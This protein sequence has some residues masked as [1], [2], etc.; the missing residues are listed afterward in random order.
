MANR[1]LSRMLGL[2]PAAPL[3]EGLVNRVLSCSVLAT[4]AVSM[5]IRQG[6]RELLLGGS[7]PFTAAV[8]KF[9][10]QYNM[11][12]V[13][14]SEPFF[15]FIL[16]NLALNWIG[17]VTGLDVGSLQS[18]SFFY[19]YGMPT[20]AVFLAWGSAQSGLTTGCRLAS[21]LDIGVTHSSTP[22]LTFEAL[23]SFSAVVYASFWL[24]ATMGSHDNR[25]D[26]RRVFYAWYFLIGAPV[27]RS[28]LLDDS[29]SFLKFRFFLERELKSAG[30]MQAWGFSS[31]ISAT[32]RVIVNV[33]TAF[34]SMWLN[35]SEKPPHNNV[36]VWIATHPACV[37]NVRAAFLLVKLGIVLPSVLLGFGYAAGWSFRKGQ[38]TI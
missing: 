11:G 21:P 32:F 2:R 25:S 13:L 34:S 30:S 18:W 38:R 37:H 16:I 7:N 35:I 10:A 17:R 24:G 31:W 26:R 20:M 8:F 15:A 23:G 27:F 5:L 12:Q 6:P 14:P 3:S 36:S 9:A 4:V 19:A 33:F 22:T 29:V 1:S 28:F